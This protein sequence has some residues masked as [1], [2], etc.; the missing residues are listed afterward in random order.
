MKARDPRRGVAE[1]ADLLE[2]PDTV[3]PELDDGERSVQ[4]ALQA[5]FEALPE[6]SR[7]T[8]AT[9]ALHPAESVGRYPAAWLADSSPRAVDADFA[10][11]LGHDLITVDAEG[12]ARPHALIR[13]LS[14]GIIARLDERSRQ[15][16]LHRLVAGYVL[17]AAAA[18][19]TLIPPR[20]QPPAADGKV[21]VAAMPFDHPAQAMAW[22]R[23]EAKLVPRLCS[24]ALEL[25]L[26]EECWRLAYAMRDYFFAVRA[27]RPWIASHRIALQAAERK[28]DRWAQATTRNNLGMAFVEQGQMQAAEAQYRQALELLRAIDDHRGVATTLGHQAWANHAAGRH[29]DAVSLAEQARELNRRHDDRRSL[30]IMDRT[31]A[32]AYA[33]SGRPAEALTLLAECQEILSEL[34]LPLD[35]AM[36]FNCL[37]EVHSTMGQ[38]GEARAF[39]ALAAEHSAA[40]GGLGEQARAVKGLA[41]ATRGEC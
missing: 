35:V 8:L 12:R 14:A 36:M 25:G 41:V 27:V 1:L 37:G 26:D 32:L 38:F 19:S 7:H 30:A 9:L 13:N 15:E 40:C 2:S 31:A 3:W 4:R 20:F 28:G 29:D 6:R 24:L 16:A 23:A 10:E 33:K 34:N 39:H 17:T 5:E 22:C 18:D 11:L 21:A